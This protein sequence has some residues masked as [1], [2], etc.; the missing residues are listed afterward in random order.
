MKGILAIL[1]IIVL[2]SRF[3]AIVDGLVSL[4]ILFSIAY[5]ISLLLKSERPG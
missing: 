4:A 1:F 5:A 2:V 3:A